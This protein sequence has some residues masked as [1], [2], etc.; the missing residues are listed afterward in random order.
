MSQIDMAKEQLWQ[1]MVDIR[2]LL[3]NP[4]LP[5]NRGRGKG[6]PEV[7]TEVKVYL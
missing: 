7:K 4:N 6:Q 1:N 5:K 2:S 3:S